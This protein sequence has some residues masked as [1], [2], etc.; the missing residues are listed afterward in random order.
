MT[1]TIDPRHKPLRGRAIAQ[2]LG[3]PYQITLRWLQAGL[4][5]A[6]QFGRV[7]STTPA[8]IDASPVIVGRAKASSEE[9]A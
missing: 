2:Y 6:D 8:R 5:D 9:A 7:Y 1:K 4:I 3:Q